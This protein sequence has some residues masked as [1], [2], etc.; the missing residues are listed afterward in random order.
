MLKIVQFGAAVLEKF[1]QAFPNTSLCKSLSPCSGAIHDP[2]DL[3]L[4]APRM[5]PAKYQCILASGS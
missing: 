4:L 1:F 5:L 3:N 2:R